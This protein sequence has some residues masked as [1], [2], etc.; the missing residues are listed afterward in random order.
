MK[1]NIL[2]LIL[3]ILGSGFYSEPWME[4]VETPAQ[5]LSAPFAQPAGQ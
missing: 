3:V 5:L 1:K 4:L 2:L